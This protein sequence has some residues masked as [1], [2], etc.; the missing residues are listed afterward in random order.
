[1]VYTALIFSKHF[2]KIVEALRDNLCEA[3]KLVTTEALR[4]M[5]RGNYNLQREPSSRLEV[6]R[7][8]DTWDKPQEFAK[9]LSFIE[10]CHWRE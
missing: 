7:P 5:K 1:M 6:Q 10:R 2:A 8:A 4:D 3:S 9:P